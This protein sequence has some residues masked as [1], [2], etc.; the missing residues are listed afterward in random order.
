MSTRVAASVQSS[1]K[2]SA[3]VQLVNLRKQGRHIAAHQHDMR[4]G[5]DVSAM[6]VAI[7]D[8]HA[9]QQHRDSR[10]H[11]SHQH[12]QPCTPPPAPASSRAN[13][14]TWQHHALSDILFR[15]GDLPST[16]SDVCH[17]VLWCDP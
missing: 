1:I 15:W 10:V 9:A 2:H 6:L 4:E 7:S 16:Q 13:A 8:T 17:P 11:V 12:L 3:L 14:P 5:D